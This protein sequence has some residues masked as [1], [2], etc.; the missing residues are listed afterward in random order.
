MTSSCSFL[1]LS[2]FLTAIALLFW[3][4][5]YAKKTTDAGCLINARG[6]LIMHHTT[7]EEIIPDRFLP[8]RSFTTV[9][10]QFKLVAVSQPFLSMLFLFSLSPLL[11]PLLSVDSSRYSLVLVWA[12]A[13]YS[14]RLERFA[15]GVSILYPKRRSLEMFW[16]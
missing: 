14:P 6:V 3:K 13:C 11:S 9:T 8:L 2:S 7:R 12:S 1:L 15:L 10:P 4:I 5:E 16:G